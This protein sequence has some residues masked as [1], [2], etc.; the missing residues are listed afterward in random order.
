MIAILVA[1]G[2]LAS[3]CK[4][5]APKVAPEVAPEITNA[6][7][8]MTNILAAPVSSRTRDLGVLLLTN[9]CDTHIQLGEGKSCTLT[10]HLINPKQ[11]QITLALETRSMDGK[12]QTLKIM[13]VVT[14]PG[15]Q[16]EMDFGSLNLTLTP[17]MAEETNSPSKT[18]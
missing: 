2:L 1:T 7:A 10:P 6:V 5:R 9:H 17:Q 3:G 8:V 4:K 16:F 12:I 14:K 13:K 15:Q 18:P 11:L